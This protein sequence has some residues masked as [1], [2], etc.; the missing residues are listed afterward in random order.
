LEK[1]NTN[2]VDVPTSNN[3]EQEAKLSL[4]Q[5]TEDYIVLRDWC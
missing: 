5:P 3:M 4:G 1:Q 2:T